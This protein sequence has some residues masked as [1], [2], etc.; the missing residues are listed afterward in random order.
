MPIHLGIGPGDLI[1]YPELAYPTYEVGAALAGARAV[2]TDSLT[3]LGPE[4]PRLLWLNSPVQ[5]DRPG[6]ARRA[7]AQGRRLVPR[8][9]HDPGL[10][11]VLPRVRVGRRARSRVL[12]PDVCGDSPRGHPRRPLA[13]Q[14]LQPRGLPLRVRRRR[15]G[16]RRRA[17][18]RPQE[19]RPADARPA[20]ARDDRR[21]RRRRPRRRAARAVRRSARQAARGAGACRLP[22]RALRGLALPVG[23]ARRG[24]LG[25]R[26]RARRPGASWSRPATSTGRPGAGTCGSPS[27]RPTSGSTRRSPASPDPSGT[28]WTGDYSAALGCRRE[29]SIVCRPASGTADGA[30]IGP[31][32][33]RWTDRAEPLRGRG[34]GTTIGPASYVTGPARRASGTSRTSLGPAPYFD[35]GSKVVRRPR[36]TSAGRAGPRTASPPAAG[37]GWTVASSRGGLDL[38]V[39]LEGRGLPTWT[40]LMLSIR[41]TDSTSSSPWS[42]SPV[43]VDRVDM[44]V[45]P[46]AGDEDVNADA[47]AL[48]P[49][50]RRT[51]GVDRRVIRACRRR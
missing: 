20:A 49:G 24:L 10:R 3:A 44:A 12:H 35:G 48:R 22:H 43:P 42:T 13:L 4:A 45:Q 19:P 9:R 18:R 38:A 27:P 28:G 36:R 8:A 5:P 16:P 40:A 32:V 1:A 15:P 41:R 11:R 34:A 2:A 37:I 14:A 30:M 47:R 33:G 17:A 31:T 26:G 25:H 29:R 23:H 6:A 46:L 51:D 50:E 7:P 39:G 21:P